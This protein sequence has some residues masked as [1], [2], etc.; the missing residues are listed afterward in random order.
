M[1]ALIDAALGRSRTTLSALLLILIAGTVAYIEIPKEADPDINIPLI[2][3]VLKHEGISPEDA[4]RLLLRPIEQEVRSIEGVKEMRSRAYEGGASIVLEFDAGFDADAA[5][6]D[7]REKIDTAKADLPEE[8]E[9]PEVHEVNFSLFPVL[10]VTLSGEIPERELLHLARTVRDAIKTLPDVL[11]AKL[12]GER[13]ELVEVVV[14]PLKLESYGLQAGNVLDAVARSNQLIAA[15]TLDTGQGRFPIKV[16]GLYEGVADILEQPIKVNG[17]AVVRIRDIAN[18]QRSFKDRAGYARLDGQPAI[19]IEVTKRT[20]ANIIDT[21]DD[22]RGVV[23]EATQPFPDAVQVTFS[24]DKSDQ[25]SLMLT[26][27]QN[28]V[29]SAILLVMIVVVGAMG[30]RSAGLVGLAIPGSFML[31]M[32]VLSSLGLT[33]NIVVLFS[34]ILAVGMLVDGA[35]V[36]TESADRRMAEGLSRR[37]A[38]AEAGKR[39]AWPIIASTATTLAAFFPL[40]FWPGVVGEFMKFLP[41]TLL[42]TLTASLLMALVFV[43]ALGAIIGKPSATDDKARTQLAAAETGDINTVTGFTGGY[44]KVLRA[45]LRHPGLVLATAFGTLIGVQAYYATHGNG[46]EFFPDI[47]PDVAL[48]Y[49]HARGDLSVEEKK[50]LV[51]P[52]EREV[53]AVGGFASVYTFIGQRS[54]GSSSGGGE[55]VAEDVIGTIQV[56]FKDW[57]ERRPAREILAD[58]VE[59]TRDFPGIYVEPRKEEAGPP[60]GKAVQIQLRGRDREDLD[61]A[62]DTVLEKFRATPGLKDVDDTR[63]V[64]GIEWRLIVDRAQAAKFGADVSLIGRYV[65]LVTKG[66][67]IT[68]YRP[69]DSDEEVD[70]VVRY[71][72]AMRT[73]AQLDRIRMETAQ[74]LV[75]IGNFVRMT[76][77]PKTGI[78]RRVDGLPA[79]TVRAD[80]AEGV[81]PDNKVQELRAW[82]PGA[83]LPAGIEVSFKGEDKEQQEA[84]AFLV[85]AFGVALFIMAIILVTQFNSF[86]SALLIL[87]AVIMSTIGVMIGLIV[88]GSPFGIVMTG[89]GV[90]ALAGIVVNNNIV[91]IDTYDT[92]RKDIADPREAVLRTGAQRLRPVMLTTVTTI[93]GLMPMV[94]QTNINFVS[95]EVTVGAPSTQWWVSL[96]TAIVF[97]LAFATVLTLVVTPAALV[98]KHDVATGW[99]RLKQR[100]AGRRGGPGTGGTATPDYELPH[101]AE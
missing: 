39:M 59:R 33:I 34:L 43:P 60:T 87:S 8:T 32:L 6:V 68:D 1:R 24:Q 41:I 75:A 54:D 7:V 10:V 82:L 2:Y 93:L 51:L 63:D 96:S 72:V 14:D 86:Y 53:L 99:R 52:V 57:L 69:N 36:V 23:T 40:L 45:A 62:A 5:L 61:T 88:T 56:E 3:T 89:I 35:I 100:L 67:K 22:V 78:I 29:T 44:L 81:L 80:V 15:G 30:V 25:I 90:I 4:E 97:G 13:P 66:M 101:A 79:I 55:D 92:L 58:I 9:E 16:P 47:E 85:K 17:D 38:Y 28:N 74:G 50:E 71:P 27:L 95:R 26:D 91:L 98:F 73:L 18:V 83:G 48:I 20:G 37:D 64:P 31:G 70:V 46:V 42:V 12:T 76:P 84:Q 77:E 21:I 19:G 11:D 94:M 65:Q 49:V